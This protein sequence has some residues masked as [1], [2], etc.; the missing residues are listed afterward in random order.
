MQTCERVRIDV[1][2]PICSEHGLQ[3]LLFEYTVSNSFTQINDL[4]FSEMAGSDSS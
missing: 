1:L 2:A 3:Y 4:E